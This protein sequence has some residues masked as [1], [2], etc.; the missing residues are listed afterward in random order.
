MEAGL[1][2]GFLGGPW[3]FRKTVPLIFYLTRNYPGQKPGAAS[4]NV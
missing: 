2:P 4:K 3:Q 1:I